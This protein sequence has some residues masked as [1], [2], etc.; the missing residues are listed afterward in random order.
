MA[1]TPPPPATVDSSEGLHDALVPE[2]R[3]APFTAGVQTDRCS[4]STGSPHTTARAAHTP[5]QI[6]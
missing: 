1:D 2:S 3:T 4:G 5:G 6:S